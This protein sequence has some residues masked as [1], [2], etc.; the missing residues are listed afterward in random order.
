[1]I[2]QEYQI[3]FDGYWRE[4]NKRGLPPKSGVF[5]VYA[6]IYQQATNMV[7]LRRL[8]YIGAAEDVNLCVANHEHLSELE[9][10][11]LPEEELCYSFGAVGFED[12]LRCEAAMIYHHRPLGNRDRV[13]LFSYPPTTIR[14]AGRAQ[15]LDPYFTVG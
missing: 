2:T 14:L 11:L 1:M 6:C 3:S 15:F 10:M 12:R 5:C 4:V 9:R 8:L 13:D 7:M